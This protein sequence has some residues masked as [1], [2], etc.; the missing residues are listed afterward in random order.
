[1]YISQAKGATNKTGRDLRV[2][3]PSIGQIARVTLACMHFPPHKTELNA[4]KDLFFFFPVC[5]FG[6]NNIAL[7]R[8]SIY[9]FGLKFSVLNM[10]SFRTMLNRCSHFHCASW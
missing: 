5:S 10:F 6:Y 3:S 4:L 8:D 2:L 1:M 9:L 7:I